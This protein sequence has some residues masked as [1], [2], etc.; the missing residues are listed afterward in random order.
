MAGRAKLGLAV[1]VRPTRRPL[2]R[3]RLPV[4]Q[5]RPGGAATPTTT[6]SSS[7]GSGGVLPASRFAVKADAVCSRL[8]ADLIAAKD[9]IRTSQDIVRIAPQRAAAEQTALTE[10][11]KLKPP[12]SMAQGY[13]QM[14]AARQALIE[15]TIRLGDYAATN[16]TKAGPPLFEASERV[17]RQM[18]A[19]ARRIGLED[20][21]RIGA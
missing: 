11:S 9:I 20:C 3:R 10:L 14:L 7:T 5:R 2:P 1:Q 18:G 8:N 6:G 15:D 17:V 16:N 4:R 12:A 21:G 19:A 13:Q